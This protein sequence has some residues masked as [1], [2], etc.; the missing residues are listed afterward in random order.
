MRREKEIILNHSMNLLLLKVLFFN[1]YYLL[2]SF[3]QMQIEK[4][5]SVELLFSFSCYYTC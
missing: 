3:S 5:K 2:S 4:R 1:E